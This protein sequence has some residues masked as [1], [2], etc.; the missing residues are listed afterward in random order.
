M[1]NK[2]AIRKLNVYLKGH[3]QQS[4]PCLV[5]PTGTSKTDILSEVAKDL[6]AELIYFDMSQQQKGDNALPT[7]KN[8]TIV[9]T[10][11]NKFQRIFDNPDKEY[12]IVCDEFNRAQKDVM[13]EW[14]KIITERTV[15]GYIFGKNVRFIATMNISDDKNGVVNELKTVFNEQQLHSIAIEPYK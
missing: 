11:N 8:K 10:L 1:D 6:N 3:N 4:L 13:S 14:M 7:L 15:H 9:Y 12:I 2:Q 5:G